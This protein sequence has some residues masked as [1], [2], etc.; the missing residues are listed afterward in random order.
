MWFNP[1]KVDA[2]YLESDSDAWHPPFQTFLVS[3]I[4][5]SFTHCWKSQ[6]LVGHTGSKCDENLRVAGTICQAGLVFLFWILSL[7]RFTFWFY[8]KYIPGC[9]KN[10]LWRLD[11]FSLILM[12][13]NEF[14]SI[15]DLLES[16]RSVLS[17]FKISDQLGSENGTRNNFP[18]G[19]SGLSLNPIGRGL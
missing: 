2:T 10:L 17:C 8:I 18:T 11:L 5:A 14:N 4:I 16:S 1:S 15:E 12:L 7:L 6:G 13:P 3:P 9:L 19:C